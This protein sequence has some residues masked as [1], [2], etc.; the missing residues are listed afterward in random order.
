MM[1]DEGYASFR[2]DALCGEG[3]PE[4]RLVGE[5]DIGTAGYL[6]SAL[7]EVAGQGATIVLD[8]SGLGFVDSS[9]LHELV[10]A[11]KRQ[12]AAGGDI[13]LRHPSPQTLRVLEIVGLTQLFVVT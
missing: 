13:V 7:A 10:V 12:R 11:V 2:V 6:R 8:L 9:G 4:L 1:S 3:Q 5:L